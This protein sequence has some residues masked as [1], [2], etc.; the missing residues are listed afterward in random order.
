VAQPAAQPQEPPQQPPP[1][2]GPSD[3]ASD[4]APASAVTRLISGM[5]ARLSQRGQTAISSRS[6]IGRSTSYTEEQSLQR[7]S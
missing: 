4:P 3:L 1:A 2:T 7:Y 5:L 6:A